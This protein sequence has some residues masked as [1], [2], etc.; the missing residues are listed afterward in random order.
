MSENKYYTP[1]IAEFHVGFEYEERVGKGL[2]ERTSITQSCD[3]EF[4][5]D[6]LEHDDGDKIRVKYLDEQDILSLGYKRPMKEQGHWVMYINHNTIP[7]DGRLPCLMFY[8]E[9]HNIIIE[10]YHKGITESFT[11]FDGTVKNKSELKIILKQL[12]I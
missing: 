1:D 11:I 12:E 2:W 4:V 6:N 10:R 9:I 8:Y 3:L 5:E 7:I